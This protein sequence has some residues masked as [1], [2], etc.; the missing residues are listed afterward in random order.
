MAVLLISLLLL[1][2]G[3]PGARHPRPARAAAAP[4]VAKPAGPI[5][6]PLPDV[7]HA[8]GAADSV[9]VYA[10][11]E[12]SAP[13][14]A[15]TDLYGRQV[16]GITRAPAAWQRDAAQ[17]LSDVLLYQQGEPAPHRL[18]E[19][20]RSRFA[21]VFCGAR[22]TVT[23]LLLLAEPCVEIRDPGGLAGRGIPDPVRW[24]ALV[25]LVRQVFPT[26][27]A[28]Q[29]LRLQPPVLEE[30]TFVDTL[31]QVLEGRGP[32][33]P[34]GARAAKLE[35]T[36]LVQVRVG[37]DGRVMQARILH[38]IPELDAAAIDAVCR[39][40]FRPAL[41][42]GRRVACWVAVPVEFALR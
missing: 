30:Y 36:V 35:G 17:I 38:S 37:V 3:H 39:W 9:I 15:R 27:A 1:A 28:V 2:A 7:I 19:P 5:G 41:S 13:G 6:A 14:G 29:R 33:Y 25:G 18:S 8:V 42:R 4:A 21:L 22:D 26:D 24:S 12:R 16:L 20:A 23:A 32:V 10:L 40:R 11:G 31:P 34:P